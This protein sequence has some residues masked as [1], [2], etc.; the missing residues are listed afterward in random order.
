[1]RELNLMREKLKYQER[2]YE[3]ELI[4]N[5]T[6]IID[7]VTDKL[8]EAAVDIGT[9]LLLMFISPSKKNRTGK[10]KDKKEK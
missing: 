6:D 5:S 8:K 7:N 10:E 2:F 3:K 9:R 4:G 1:M